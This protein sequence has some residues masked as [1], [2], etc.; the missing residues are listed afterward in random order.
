MTAWGGGSHLFLLISSVKNPI[1]ESKQIHKAVFK[2][3]QDTFKK[4]VWREFWTSK[5]INGECNLYIDRQSKVQHGW[6]MTL[7]STVMHI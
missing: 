4:N 5:E 7:V 2:K 3:A 1:L 6:A